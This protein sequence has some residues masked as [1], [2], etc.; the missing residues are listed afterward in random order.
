MDA[1][2][3]KDQIDPIIRSHRWLVCVDALA[4][5]TPML[6]QWAEIG[7][8]RPL[9]ICG[10]PGTGDLPEAELAEVIVLDTGGDSIMDGFRRFHAAL[11]NPDASLVDRIDA[12]DPTGDALV[13]SHF[14][15]SDFRLAGRRPYGERLPEWKLLEDKMIVDDLWDASGVPRAPSAIVAAEGSALVEAAAS[16]DEGAGTVW[17]ADNKLGWHGGA[18]Y[19]RYVAD[20]GD[21]GGAV[22]FFEACADRVRVMPFL[23]GVPC[24]IH[25]MVFPE[26][27]IVGRPIE[28]L[29]FRRPESDRF[30]YAGL[31]SG[32]DPPLHRR[33]EMQEAARRV[34]VHLRESVGYRGALSIDGVMTAEGFRP[35]ELNARVSPGVGIQGRAAGDLPLGWIN[36]ALLEGEEL[37][38]RP[39]ELGELIVEAADARRTIRALCP[40]PAPAAESVDLPVAV[41][42]G[43]IAVTDGEPHGRLSFGP[44]AQGGL[45][46][47]QVEP[48]HVPVGP[49]VAPL[50]AT[51]F[52][53]A[54]EVWDTAIGPLIE[55]AR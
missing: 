23:E 32:W 12:W 8:A 15:D 22:E 49:S 20:P 9:V 13:F 37:D 39:A 31:A 55:G 27:V 7:T 2:F 48:E 45:V 36:R 38:Y 42:N 50:V 43:R 52:A 5:A 6:R 25:P 44:S 4:G 33:L 14:L 54:D 47:L 53:T 40:V 3:W 1:S 21:P 16:L 46:M 41:E 17:V 11:E 51:A 26:E 18:E 34:A 29:I 35:T 19:A 28:M 24:S 10:T 30:R